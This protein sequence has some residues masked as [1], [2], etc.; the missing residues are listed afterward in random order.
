[1]L[2][3]HLRPPDLLDRMVAPCAWW[4]PRQ[5]PTQVE[6]RC[7]DDAAGEAKVAGAQREEQPRVSQCRLVVHTH[8]H[9]L[10]RVRHEHVLHQQSARDR[11]AHAQWVP[12]V[13]DLHAVT[14][15]RYAEQSNL[16]LA[17]H[18]T[19]DVVESGGPG[20]RREDLA[21]GDQPPAIDRDRL[22]CDPGRRPRRKALGEWL[23]VNVAALD[24]TPEHLRADLVVAVALLGCHVQQI[25]DFAAPQHG[26]VVHVERQA[27]GT[28]VAADLLADAHVVGVAGAEPTMAGRHADTHQPVGSEVGEVLER[29][30]GFQVVLHG[31]FLH[32]RA[33]CRHEGHHFVTC[34][35]WH[36]ITTVMFCQHC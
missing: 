6:P 23:A 10:V 20:E 27:A 26:G 9:P 32:C 14:V 28:A 13:D 25:T 36:F 21:T 35:G 16:V 3:L 2:Q 5:L 1:M 22:G 31:P 34:H 15:A 18:L 17:G 4:H 19:R 29:E 24:D 11:A 30:A 33:H 7:V 12:V 8:R